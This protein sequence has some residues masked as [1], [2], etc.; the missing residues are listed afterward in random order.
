MGTLGKLVGKAWKFGSNVDTDAIIPYQYKART[1]DPAE[2]GR[3]CM[4]GLD[5]DFP[6][7]ID[8]GDFIVAGENF[9]CGSSREQAPMAIKGCGIAAVLAESFARIFFRNA[10]NVGLPALECP[11]ITD[12]VDGGD[13]LEVDLKEGTIVNLTKGR[14]LSAVKLPPFLRELLEAGGLVNYYK[15]NKRFPWD[16]P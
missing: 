2:L 8:K 13:K 7:K 9:G 3:H 6:R 15:A 4:E 10:I 11:G 12:A 16:K 14:K 1:L 5:P